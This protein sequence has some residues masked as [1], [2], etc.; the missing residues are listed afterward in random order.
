MLANI[1]THSRAKSK[2]GNDDDDDDW[3]A[4]SESI[5]VFSARRGSWRT[6]TMLCLL[7]GKV[8]QSESCLVSRS[9]QL[10]LPVL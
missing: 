5:D 3:E 1:V 7:G 2:R 8:G 9:V 6:L 4:L 10:V